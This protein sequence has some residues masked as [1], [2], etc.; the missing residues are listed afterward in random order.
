MNDI[1]HRPYR[2][3]LPPQQQQQPPLR[4]P[5]DPPRV[6]KPEK[7]FVRPKTPLLAVEQLIELG[8]TLK[9]VGVHP[10]ATNDA[11]AALQEHFENLPVRWDLVKDNR[12]TEFFVLAGNEW[13]PAVYGE[14]VTHNRILEGMLLSRIENADGSVES[15][16][17]GK[18]KWA[19]CTADNTVNY[20][21]LDPIDPPEAEV[22]GLA[23]LDA[24]GSEH[25][26]RP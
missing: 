6:R 17:I 21:W 26:G 25:E 12:R 11:R 14:E 8:E 2:K 16:P 18:Y 10:S 22:A 23:L 3:P 13:F 15:G 7:P 1:P 9:A 4:P 24:L 20:H 5:A 19:H